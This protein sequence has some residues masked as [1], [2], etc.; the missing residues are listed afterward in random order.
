MV[1]FKSNTNYVLNKIKFQE[2]VWHKYGNYPLTNPSSFTL[3]K[4]S[5]QSPLNRRQLFHFS[6]GKNTGADQARNEILINK[7]NANNGKKVKSN[8]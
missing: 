5:I 8:S 7:K 4:L 1:I 3:K 6:R 2:L